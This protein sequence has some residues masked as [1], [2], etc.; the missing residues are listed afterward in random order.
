MGRWPPNGRIPPRR[1]VEL[2]DGKKRGGGG[3]GEKQMADCSVCLTMVAALLH[4]D[5]G[6]RWKPEKRPKTEVC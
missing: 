2:A 6:N 3:E 4:K 1:Y 5:E